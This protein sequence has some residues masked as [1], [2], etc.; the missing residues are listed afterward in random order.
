MGVYRRVEE[1]Q[2]QMHEHGSMGH[3]LPE[4]PPTLGRLLGLDLGYASYVHP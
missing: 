1:E 4:L 3:V 2:A